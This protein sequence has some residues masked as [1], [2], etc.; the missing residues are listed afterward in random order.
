MSLNAETVFSLNILNH[1]LNVTTSIVVQWI[2]M[3]VIT[4]L[5]VIL[6]RDLKEI[7]DKRQSVLEMIVDFINGLV[8]SNMGSR[9]KSFVPFIGTMGIFLFFLNLSGL[10]GVEPSTKDINVTAGFALISFVVINGNAFMKAGIKGYGKKL[11]EPFPLM[12]PMNL[13]EKFTLPISLCLRLFCNMLVGSI[14]I[15]LLYQLSHITAFVIPIPFHFFFD[16]FDGIIQV[17]IFMMLTMLYTRM[18]AEME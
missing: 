6:T 16:V 14:I 18:G 3:I 1:T 9:Y 4:V 13:I 8:S 5:V 11:I 7:P 12:F 15:G 2:T 17:Y 10:V